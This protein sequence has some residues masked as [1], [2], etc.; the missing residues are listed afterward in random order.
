MTDR[1]VD[2]REAVKTIAAG[3]VG[4]PLLLGPSLA[5]AATPV[6]SLPL[7]SRQARILVLTDLHFFCKTA[8]H[9]RLT[10]RL[11]GK[12]IDGFGPDLLV[13]DGDNWHN[14]PMGRGEKFCR[15]V[16]REMGGFGLPW[17]YVR[18]N[19][20]LA[21]DFVR[22]EEMLSAARNS[23]YPSVSCNAN[24]RVDLSGPDGGV[25]RRLLVLND[26][27]PELGF[28]ADEAD[29]LNT[30]TM[31]A[32]GSKDG[33]APCFLFCHIPVR[34]FEDLVRDGDAHGI[35]N[36]NVCHEN[37]LPDAINTIS[38]SGLVDAMFCGHDHVNDYWGEA[39]GV[40]LEYVRATGYGGYGRGKV[41]KGG[42]LIVTGKD[43]PRQFEALSVFGDREEWKPEG[44]PELV[45]N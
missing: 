17:V 27:L 35:M 44:V 21:D 16:C 7:S 23:L 1:K 20:D 26:S 14:N 2:R 31:E 40:H 37:G 42:T 34:S 12:L 36:E 10:L 15:S 19:H 41:R 9:D 39:S 29:R 4:A 38:G 28:G 43:D 45:K 13:L 24:Y 30:M 11:I 22:C 25:F 8:I 33:D 3:A 32:A 6:S 18:G 5:A